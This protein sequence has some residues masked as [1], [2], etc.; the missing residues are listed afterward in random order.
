MD[1]GWGPARSSFRVYPVALRSDTKR[2]RRSRVRNGTDRAV[3]RVGRSGVSL[4]P[5]GP[6][7]SAGRT[8]VRRVV[9]PAGRQAG[10]ISA[11]LCHGSYRLA[12]ALARVASRTRACQQPAALGS[13]PFA[14]E[15]DER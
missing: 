1:S 13:L 10:H 15:M 12:V 4:V 9:A 3:P 14:S 11:M 6:G 2:T 7:R 5:A 8:K